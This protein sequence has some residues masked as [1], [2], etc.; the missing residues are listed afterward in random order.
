[1]KKKI[2]GIILVVIVL[3]VIAIFVINKP[4]IKKVDKV[5]N[6]KNI[7]KIKEKKE[8]LHRYTYKDGFYYEHISSKLKKK[9]TGKSFSSAF[10]EH[11]TSISYD[12]IKYLRMKYYDFEGKEHKDGEM[13]VHY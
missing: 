12:D 9:I 2:I 4:K 8:E 13:I 1:M 7:T 5:D 3:I 11:Y 6:V 10:D